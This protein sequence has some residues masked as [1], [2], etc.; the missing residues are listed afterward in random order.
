MK[1][2][3][4]RQNF[5]QERLKTTANWSRTHQFFFSNN[6]NV[7]SFQFPK[8]SIYIH[9]LECFRQKVHKSHQQ[10]KNVELRSTDT[11]FCDIFVMFWLK[12]EQRKRTRAGLL[13]N[14]RL[15]I[16]IKRL[17][18]RSNEQA[19]RF[20]AWNSRAKMSAIV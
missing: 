8:N 2:R 3:I 12:K 20:V 1:N 4:A 9:F 6:D 10:K 14:R 7:K 16:S 18:K 19:N 17:T 13:K 15:S 5:N 11:D